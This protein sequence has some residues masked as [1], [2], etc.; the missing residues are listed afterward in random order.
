MVD[1]MQ[2]SSPLLMI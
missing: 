2:H 1:P